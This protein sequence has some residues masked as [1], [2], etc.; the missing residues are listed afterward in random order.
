MRLSE[1]WDRAEDALQAKTP[2]PHTVRVYPG[3]A[4]LSDLIPYRVATIIEWKPEGHKRNRNDRV[5]GK[6]ITLTEALVDFAAQL[7]AYEG[8]KPK[9]YDPS[10]FEDDEDEA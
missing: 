8:Y 9:P 6:G 5:Q 1:A 3:H 2:Y 10:M 4:G 7:E